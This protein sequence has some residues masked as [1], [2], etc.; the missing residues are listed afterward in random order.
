LR[1][2]ARGIHPPRVRTSFSLRRSPVF[3][4]GLVIALFLAFVWLDSRRHSSGV[5]FG[6][7]NGESSYCKICAQNSRVLFLLWKDSPDPGWRKLF[8]LTLT[9]LDL[10]PEDMAV[11]DDSLP[12][13]PGH[14]G[15]SFF[16]AFDPAAAGLYVAHR[17]LDFT[18]P[19]WA[20]LLTHLCLWAA[21]LRWRV[22]RH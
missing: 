2:P 3:W 19:C 20:L 8:N 22:K 5:L 13:S 1:F 6:E 16:T 11:F 12:G 10:K 7:D 18:V 4:G 21:A 17:D 14:A 15:F 9:R